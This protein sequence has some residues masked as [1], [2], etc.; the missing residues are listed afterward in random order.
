MPLTRGKL[1]VTMVNPEVLI[2]ANIDRPII[3]T[4]SIVMDYCIRHSMN[5]DN[6]LQCSFRAIWNNLCMHFTVA[7]QDTGNDGFAVS[8]PGLFFL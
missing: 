4:P 3:T 5:M 2:E 7:F 8:A 1:I 6:G